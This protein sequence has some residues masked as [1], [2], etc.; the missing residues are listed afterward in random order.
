M[1][2]LQQYSSRMLLFQKKPILCTEELHEMFV[3]T[4]FPRKHCMKYAAFWKEYNIIK[5]RVEN[6]HTIPK[7]NKN[8][9]ISQQ[10]TYK[11]FLRLAL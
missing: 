7:E 8:V 3:H 11:C 9:I 6:D 2:I 4:C 10:V 1:L 5:D